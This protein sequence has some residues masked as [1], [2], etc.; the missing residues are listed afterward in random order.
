MVE[1]VEKSLDLI[2]PVQTGVQVLMAQISNR[3]VIRERL[4]KLDG[5]EDQ[6]GLVRSITDLVFD[7][8]GQERPN[9]VILPE[10]SVP[11]SK[12]AELIALIEDRAQVNTVFVF[13]VEHITLEEYRGLLA[14]HDGD[15]EEAIRA[16]DDDWC[17]DE[18]HKP[19]NTCT[20][21]VK[22]DNGATRCFFLAKTHPF[23][24]EETLDHAF[25][26]YRGKVLALFRCLNVS[27][28]FMPLI[29]FDYVYRDMLNSN[30]MDIIR[31]ANDIF[32]RQKQ[33][34][35]MLAVIQ[36]NPKPEHRV[37]RDVLTGFYGEYLFKMPGVRDTM[38]LFLNTSAAT[39][40]EGSPAAEDAFGH[41]SIVCGVRH[42][43][44][45]IKLSEFRTDDYDGAPVSRLRFGAGDRLYAAS[46]FPHHE[47]D[48]RSSRAMVKVAGIY[49]PEG[50]SAWHRMS[51][52]ELL[53]GVPEAEALELDIV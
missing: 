37:F 48:P 43:L 22:E 49:R 9:F 3:L 30:I 16:A 5:P 27:F 23:A 2:L 6:F 11:F 24:G 53:T 18:C 20:V 28:N 38:T 39:R 51:G 13:G 26:L 35:D 41:S 7:L 29:C 46:L 50:R 34:L 17:L 19:V 44:P 21:V 45:K 32:F 12:L 33:G 40:L 36:C 10:S 15:N 52:D 31:K 8:P 1:I 47:T 4:Y 25:D 42:K 14:Q